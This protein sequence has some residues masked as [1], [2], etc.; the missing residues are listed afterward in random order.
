MNRLSVLALTIPLLVIGGSLPA[1]HAVGQDK[2]APRL[3]HQQP[4]GDQRGMPE[5][6]GMMRQMSGMMEHCHRMMESHQQQHPTP[7][8]KPEKEG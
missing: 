7:A 1:R 5:M 8:P 6:M 3:Q 4:S 2:S